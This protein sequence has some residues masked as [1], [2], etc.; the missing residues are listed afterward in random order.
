MPQLILLLVC[1][2]AL[3]GARA[4]TLLPT[5]VTGEEPPT[6]FMEDGQLTGLVTETVEALIKQQQLNIPIHY[7]PWAR[8]FRL[9]TSQPNVM[10]FTAGK[11]QE[12]IDQGFIFI[13]PVTTRRHILYQR[14]GRNLTIHSLEDVKRQGLRGA[15]MREDWRGKF[16]A[17]QNIDV[18]L[19]VSHTQSLKMLNAGR[20]DLVALSDLELKINLQNAEVAAGQ[21]KP[22]FT[23]DVRDAYLMFSKDSDPQLIARWQQAL[24]ELQASD[25]FTHTAKK[26]SQRLGVELHYSPEKGFYIP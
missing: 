16:L 3:A 14:A 21:V 12:R 10:I 25:Y 18:V 9:V 17:Q 8:A 11:T 15:S 1:F 2:I 20:V 6:N 24:T 5:V 23:F 7:Y 22:A 19:N 26:W 13:G 4:D